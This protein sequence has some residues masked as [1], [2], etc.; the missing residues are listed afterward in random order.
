MQT[1]ISTIIRV[2]NR[3]RP[4]Y[5]YQDR[6]KDPFDD[7]TLKALGLDVGAPGEDTPDKIVAAVFAE[8]KTLYSMQQA[9][10]GQF[11]ALQEAKKKVIT[12]FEAFKGGPLNGQPS[13]TR[14]Q[15]GR[16]AKQLLMD[17]LTH[18][19]MDIFNHEDSE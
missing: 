17:V 5:L 15:G 2:T 12:A 18:E 9:V 13:R 6:S 16:A 14:V 7:S 1:S 8:I 4:L 19:S 10:F 11:K 3:R